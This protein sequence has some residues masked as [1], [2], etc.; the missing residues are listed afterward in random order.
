MCGITGIVSKNINSKKYIKDMADKIKHRGPDEE[1]FY[2][3]NLIA[4]AHRRLSIIDLKNGKQP[5]KSDDDRYVLIFNGEIYNYQELRKDLLNLGYQ[6]TTE[7][8]TE[9][10]LK[11]YIEYQEKILN[12]LR[13]MFAFAIW[14]KAKSTLFCA[15]DHFG[16]KPFYYYKSDNSFLFASEIKAFIDHPEF[17]KEV[18]KK[19]LVPYLE[20]SFNPTNE[21]FFK[22]VY[23]LEPGSYLIYKDNKIKVK[24]YYELSFQEKNEDYSLIVDKI[25]SVVNDSLQHHQLSDVPIGAF[26]SSGVDSSY[27]VSTLKP[28]NTYTIG[29]KDKRYSE[30]PYT[31]ELARDLNIKNN[32]KYINRDEYIRSITDVMYYMDEPLPDPA[33]VSLYHLAKFAHQYVK[34]ILSGEGA[35]E[36]FAGY[37]VYREGIDMHFYNKIPYFLRHILAIIVN[38]LPEFKGKNFIIRR[39]NKIEDY[40]QGVNKLFSTNEI[41]KVLNKENLTKHEN[42]TKSILANCKNKSDLIKMQTCDIHLWLVKDILLKVDKMTM[43]SSIEARTPFVDKEVFEVAKRLPS[44]HKVT[45]ENTKVAFRSAAKKI[46]PTEAYKK[47]KLGFPVPLREWMREEDVYNE[48]YISF[49]QA[50]VHDFF[51][52]R[53]IIKLLQEHKE[54]KKDNYKK[55]WAIYCFIK[56]YEVFFLK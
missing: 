16:M 6:F 46:I 43:A 33:A 47:K 50:F 10:L 52:K 3:D 5:I 2:N 45:K 48:I 18:N 12:H 37:N 31:K 53:Y 1:G 49:K 54:N 8:D 30:T 55:I 25:G 32:C 21:T 20:F 23:S 44:Q 27:I 7:C 4:L 34:V 56:W 39:G 28:E 35:D 40:Y 41:R 42:I 51:D 29:Y 15:R 14:D 26:L 13:G 36:F 24:K 22:G 38:P 11:G 17:K 19:L 9:V